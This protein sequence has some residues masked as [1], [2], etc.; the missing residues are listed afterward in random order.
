VD[1]VILFDE[2]TPLKL[3]EKVRPDILVKGGDYV[4]ENI[5]GYDL[6]TSYGGQVITLPFIEGKSTTN[7]ISK[8]MNL[9]G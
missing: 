7:I 8:I 2:D 1:Y 5:V 6:L 3:L 9:K 4:K